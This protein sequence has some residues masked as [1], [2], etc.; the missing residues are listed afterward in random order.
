LY[1]GTLAYATKRGAPLI[2]GLSTFWCYR[3]FNIS[4]L[5]F[6]GH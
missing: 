4:I 3:N 6:D 5:V 1:T 2:T